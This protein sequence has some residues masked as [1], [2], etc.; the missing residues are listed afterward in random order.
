MWVGV[1]VGYE[2]GSPLIGFL[3]NAY[4]WPLSG[5]RVSYFYL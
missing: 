4:L 5:L 1:E 3:I 2:V